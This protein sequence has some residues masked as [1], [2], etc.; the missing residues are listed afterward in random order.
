MLGALLVLLVP[1]VLYHLNGTATIASE[2]SLCPFKMLTGFPCPG[3]GITKSLVFLYAGNW[4][5]SF[6]F[7]L[8]GPMVWIGAFMIFCWMLLELFT[9][10]T[11][12]PVLFYNAKLA[13][14]LA[15]L[16][17]GYHLIRLIVFI[18]EHQLDAILRESVW[19]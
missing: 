14:A 17:A 7:H 11:Y 15:I 1:W 2:Q 18:R 8:F 16:L 10:N 5:A 4:K 3:C 6:Q 12:R 9:G 13:Y 19:K